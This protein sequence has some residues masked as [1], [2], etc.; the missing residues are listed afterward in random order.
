M[1]LYRLVDFICY[2]NF[3]VKSLIFKVLRNKLAKN[4]EIF[5]IVIFKKIKIVSMIII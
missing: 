2:G 3:Y 5:K 1:V 4:Y